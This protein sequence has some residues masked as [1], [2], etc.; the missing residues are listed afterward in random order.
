VHFNKDDEHIGFYALFFLFPTVF[1]SL[2]FFMH[3]PH[4]H[5]SSG[6]VFTAGLGSWV[7]VGEGGGAGWNVGCP[8]SSYR[9][10][11][12]PGGGGGG[13]FGIHIFPPIPVALG[14]KHTLG[15]LDPSL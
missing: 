3:P 5:R 2:N 4:T 11:L 7:G 12:E 13:D 9:A 15:S 6:V 14:S 1:P 8:R 10:T